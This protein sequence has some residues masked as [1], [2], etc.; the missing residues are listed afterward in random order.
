[1]NKIKERIEA[2]RKEMKEKNLQAYLINGSDPHM[3]E[4]V[5]EHWQS[6]PFMSG[7]TGSFGYMAVTTDKA[8]LWTDSRYYLQAGEELKDTGIEMMKAREPEAVTLE[9]WITGEL[10]PGSTVG[11]D[12]T[13]YS[14]AEVEGFETV[15]GKNEL[16]I[17]SDIDLL[18]EVWENRPG[19]P[20]S[21]AFLH[22]TKWAGL[23]RSDKFSELNKELE[24]SGVDLMVLSALDDIGW[25]FNIRGADV[26]CNPVVLAFAV[27]GKNKT[28][29]FVDKTKFDEK[30]LSELKNDG[31]EVKPYES[32]YDEL[33][34]IQGQ[35]VMIDPARSNYRIYNILE[36][37]NKVV[38]QL[39]VPALLKSCKNEAELAGMK[40][41]HVSDGI[42]LLDFQLWLEEKLGKETITEYNVAMKLEEFRSKQEGYVGTSFFPIVG[43]L[44]HGAIV[45][46]RV[47]PETA[48]EL[49]PEGIMLFDSG[50]QYEYG[51]TDITRTISLGSVTYKMKRDFTQVLKGM[52]NLSNVKFPKGTR[53]CHLDV[54]ARAALWNDQKNYGHG[55]GHGVGA[56]MNVH[57]GPGSIRPD[58]NNQP[59]RPGNIFS[60]E[61]GIYRAGEYG[62]RIE[63]LIHVVE[64]VENEFGTFYKFE[65]L[66]KFPI[67]TKLIDT[68]L[69]TGDE[70]NWINDY[71]KD[72]LDSLSPLAN[73]EQ[74]QLLRRLTMPL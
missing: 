37:N 51:T 36:V 29:L 60:D 62:I 67:C 49:K 45:H 27:I 12:G 57:E 18:N 56:F 17:E 73:A 14:F 54:L 10:Q 63:N 69:L 55:T 35:S 74:T 25:T 28:E 20:D 70:I 6:R 59:L 38:R 65:T 16:R 46:F 64:G 43:Y 42:A 30:A 3:S 8:A 15:F 32:F 39:S 24:K 72:V 19:M 48:N 58:L 4:Y 23:S 5:P 26:E 34:A 47:S 2:L 13:C 44:H 33:K 41:A 31:V 66:T 68:S 21:K 7:F 71:H 22:P 1:M 11:F 50:G 40:K 52:I 9:Q 61:P 53:G